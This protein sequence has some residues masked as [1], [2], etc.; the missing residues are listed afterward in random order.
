MVYGKCK[1][2]KACVILRFLK[3]FVS[4]R[5]F[6]YFLMLRIFLPKNKKVF[7]KKGFRDY[8]FLDSYS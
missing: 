8:Y 1:L 4:E 5:Q 2:L 6:K 3:L 7:D